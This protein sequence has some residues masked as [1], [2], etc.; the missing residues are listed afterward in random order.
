MDHVE[1]RKRFPLLNDLEEGT[2]GID[3]QSAS[4]CAFRRKHLFLKMRKYFPSDC[5]LSVKLVFEARDE[6]VVKKKKSFLVSRTKHL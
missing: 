2:S 3:I 6:D 4:T 1:E 5:V